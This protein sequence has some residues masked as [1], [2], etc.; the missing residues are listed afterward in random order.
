ML[1]L[2]ISGFVWGKNGC[3]SYYAFN[4]ESIRI[5]EAENITCSWVDFQGDEKKKAE[6]IDDMVNAGDDCYGMGGANDWRKTTLAAVFELRTGERQRQVAVM[7]EFEGYIMNEK[8]ATIE[9][10]K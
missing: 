3:P 10:I 1:T 4:G 5:Y 6:F 7:G 2:K 8:G 9:H